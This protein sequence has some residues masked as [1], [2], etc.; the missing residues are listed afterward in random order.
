MP[1]AR[2]LL[3][4]LLVCSL[5]CTPEEE[6]APEPAAPDMRLPPGLLDPDELPLQV[7]KRCPGSPGCEDVG[8]GTLYAG[9]AI[10]DITPQ[11][12]PF[13]DRNGNRLRDADEPFE[14]RNG[15]GR[16][17]A[18]WIA[19]YGTGRLALGVHDPVWAR[20]LALRQNQTTVV[21]VSVDTLGL[22]LE[23]TEEVEKLLDPALGIDLLLL[24]ATHLHQTADLVGGWGP[25]PL[26]YGVN[27]HYQQRVRRAIASAVEE[28]VRRLRPVR[29]TLGSIAVQDADGDMRR[30]VSDTRDPVII[31]NVLHTMQFSEIGPQ[32]QVTPLATLINWAHHPEAVGASNHLIT[33]DFVHYLRERVE[34]R[35]GGT[36]VYVS[37]ALGG[38]IGPGRV[39]AQ[40]ADGRI[41]REKGFPKAEAIGKA[42]AGFALMAMADPGARTV[43][44]PA[45]RLSFRT[46]RFAAQVANRKFHLAAMLKIYRR[47]YCCHDASR[48]I[49]EDNLP[50][51]ETRVAYLQLGPASIITNP[52]E[53]HP[54]LFIGGYD[55][56][57]SGTYPLID[58]SKPNAADLSRAPRPPYLIDIMDGERAHRMTWGLTMDF[59]G[60][61][62]PRFNFVLHERRPYLEQAP[63]DHYEET[64]SLGPLAEPHIVGTMR[65]LILDG[66]PNEPR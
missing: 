2:H 1:A 36:V 28:A 50:S 66:R 22:F 8:D 59:V 12:E 38:Q 3:P 60:Y 7:E 19:G 51:I 54:E 4:L 31:D 43:A 58:L 17:D 18:Y 49:D 14:D 23:E 64:N 57:R 37:G 62:L 56:S 46:A 42:V 35:G 53:L 44:G 13:E 65:Q 41:I 26:T 25:D 47:A 10:R 27:E 30:Y 6:P 9:V 39:E 45:A 20:A 16:F 29:V 40:D 34:Q 33:S 61:I 21:L 52:G 11:V 63:G 32:G 15:N 5:A 55:G 48:P 24:H